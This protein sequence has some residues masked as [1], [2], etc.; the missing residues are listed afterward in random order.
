M[1]RIDP[2]LAATLRQPR[3]L[4]DAGLVDR[5]VDPT[6]RRA[7]VLRPTERGRA[8]LAGAADA[9]AAVRAEA[10]AGMADDE[11]QQFSDLLDRVIANL[12]ASAL[13]DPQ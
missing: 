2:K 12:Q 13:S 9:A 3:E 1:N 7:Y 4:I 8:S 10:L 5:E 11:A 6:D